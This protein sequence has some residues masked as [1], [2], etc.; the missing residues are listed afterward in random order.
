MKVLAM[1][2]LWWVM[3]TG[4]VR[5]T[6]VR[7]DDRGDVPGWVMVTVETAPQHTYR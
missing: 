6:V 2:S 1:I 3:S 5:R 4:C 7:R